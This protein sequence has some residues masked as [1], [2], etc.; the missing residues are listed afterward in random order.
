MLNTVTVEL[1]VTVG[2]C[3]IYRNCCFNDVQFDN[4]EYFSLRGAEGVKQCTHA[5]ACVVMKG[6]NS[7]RM[8]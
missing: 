8:H 6:L 4:I 1:N 7:A 2:V 5:L 3:D